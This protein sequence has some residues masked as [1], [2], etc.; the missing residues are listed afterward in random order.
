MLTLDARVIAIAVRPDHIARF[1]N[2]EYVGQ[3]E[4][5]AATILLVVETGFEGREQRSSRIHI[6]TQ[7]LALAI[8]EQGCVWQNQ[9]GIFSEPFRLQSIFVNEIEQEPP[10]E[11]R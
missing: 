10:F 6:G 3:A 7:L 11:Q 2:S 8:A 5:A 4:V 9:R 1:V